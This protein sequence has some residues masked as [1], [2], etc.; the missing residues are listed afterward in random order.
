MRRFVIG[1]VHGCA[2]AL[3]TLVETIAPKGD[4]ELIFV[5]DYVDRGPDSRG[6]VDQ[7][8][9]L[10]DQCRVVALRGNHEIMLMA[11]AFGGVESSAWF[12]SGGLA[13]VSSYGGSLRKMP[14]QHIAFFQEL[15]PY[16][17]TENEVF[18]HASYDPNLPMREQ[19]DTLIYWTHLTTPLPPPHV[20]GKRFF[21]GH[22]PQPFGQILRQ[23][24]LVCVDTC[25]FGNGYLSAMNVDTGEV[26]QTDRHGHLRRDRLT[27][28]YDQIA[29]VCGAIKRL[30]KRLDRRNAVPHSDK[31]S[32]FTG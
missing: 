15:R 29:S 32:S 21:V 28:F 31:C 18:V 13:T 2:K 17:E 9:E 10:K 3:R 19:P 25:C 12:N 24:H 16:Y 26:I 22:T 20:S 5:G 14:P 4:D 6:V 30:G 11:A 8:I 1:D 27:D 7:V 23:E